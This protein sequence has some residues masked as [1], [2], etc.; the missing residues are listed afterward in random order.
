M[1]ALTPRLRWGASPRWRLPVLLVT[2]QDFRQPEALPRNPLRRGTGPGERRSP[3]VSTSTPTP[4]SATAPGATTAPAGEAPAQELVVASR[5]GVVSRRNFLRVGAAGGGLVAFY[6]ARSVLAPTL[7]QRGL[8]SPDG[9]FGAASTAL[10]GGGPG[11]CGGGGGG[12]GGPGR[13]PEPLR[14]DV[15][16]RDPGRPEHRPDRLAVLLRPRQ[17][18]RLHRDAVP[19]GRERHRHRADRLPDRRRGGPLRRRAGQ[20]P[21]RRAGSS[22]RGARPGPHQGR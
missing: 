2:P 18:V 11:G 13:P 9:V 3:P 10:A 1:V 5:G 21:A 15:P 20:Q 6:A 14:P 22:R 12:E 19:Q 8:L 17:R 7:Q 16:D 4:S